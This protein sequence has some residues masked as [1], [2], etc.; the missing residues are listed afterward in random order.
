MSQNL[1]EIVFDA[2]REAAALVDEVYQTDFQ[3]DYKAPRDPVTLADKRAN[4]LLTERLAAAFS[5]AVIVA[6]ESDPASFA[7][8][9]TANRVFF[10]DPLDGT[11]EFIAKNGEFVVMVGYVESGRATAG[12][13]YAPARKTGWIGHLKTGTFEVRPDG[14]R[15]QVRVRPTT[16]LSAARVVASR[17]HRDGAAQ[18]ALEALGVAQIDALGSAG[19]KGSE[20]A[21]GAADAYVSPGGAGKRWDACPVDALVSAAGGRVT[22]AY[23]EVFDYRS[24]NLVNDRGM[25]AS[26][27]GIH[28]ALLQRLAQAREQS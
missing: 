25:V 1:V 12:V 15:Q 10:V 3:V 9:R 2:V 13:I 21:K 11:K 5:D 4:E 17:S 22:N 23:G 20:V 16:E 14:S 24:E 27:G 6:E 7:G 26:G 18:Q 28:D 19:L 8:Y